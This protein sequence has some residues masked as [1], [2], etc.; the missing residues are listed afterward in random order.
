MKKSPETLRVIATQTESIANQAEARQKAQQKAELKA[1]KV[2][3]ALGL[4]L[5]E[6]ISL[7]EEMNLDFAAK[8]ATARAEAVYRAS[9]FSQARLDLS[10]FG[11]DNLKQF[12]HKEW[13]TRWFKFRYRRCPA[14]KRIGWPG[15]RAPWSADISA[16]L[17]AAAPLAMSKPRR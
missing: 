3:A 5:L 1:Q 13:V 14:R 4:R 8:T 12:L 11:W 7:A 15:P 2:A 17:A 16:S 10:L 6:Q 9:A